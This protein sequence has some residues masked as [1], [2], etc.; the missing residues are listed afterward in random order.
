MQTRKKT[1]SQTRRKNKREARSSLYCRLVQRSKKGRRGTMCGKIQ[2][3]KK[4]TRGKYFWINPTNSGISKFCFQSEVIFYTGLLG[5]KFSITVM[6][7]NFPKSTVHASLNENKIEAN[8]THFLMGFT[9]LQIHY[10]ENT[11][12]HSQSMFLKHN[13]NNFSLFFQQKPS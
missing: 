2:M 10:V 11:Q 4:Y 6:Q 1:S 12:R 5:S 3:E 13:C 8:S 9:S 7:N